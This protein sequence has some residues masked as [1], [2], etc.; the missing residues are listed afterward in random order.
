M[1]GHPAVDRRPDHGLPVRAL[2]VSSHD[3]VEPPVA[4]HQALQLEAAGAQQVDGLLVL[5]GE[6]VQ[7]KNVLKL[8]TIHMSTW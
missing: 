1:Q 5:V 3:L 2:K 7:E 8:C 4:Q 6:P